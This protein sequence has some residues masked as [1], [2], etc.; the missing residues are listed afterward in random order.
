MPENVFLSK[1]FAAT[2]LILQI[3]TLF[4]FANYRWFEEEGGIIPAFSQFLSRS[5]GSKTGHGQNDDKKTKKPPNKETEKESSNVSSS[6][7][8]IDILQIVFTSNFIGIVFA[9]SLHYQFYA[10]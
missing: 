8:L 9:R 2:L 10:W 7:G 6:I 3:V 5:S 1:E 4:L